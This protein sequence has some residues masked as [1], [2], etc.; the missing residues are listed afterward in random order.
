VDRAQEHLH[1]VVDICNDD[2]YILDAGEQDVSSSFT[3][4][5]GIEIRK[6]SWIGELTP[7]RDVDLSSSAKT[8]GL[9]VTSPISLVGEAAAAGREFIQ[10]QCVNI[11]TPIEPLDFAKSLSQDHQVSS[12]SDSTSAI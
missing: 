10:N 8:E 1:Y 6:G 3:D 4:I 2:L 9:S 11:N 5:S 12:P 7:C